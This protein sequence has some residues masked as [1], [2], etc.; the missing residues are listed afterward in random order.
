MKLFNLDAAQGLELL[1]DFS[2]DMVITSPPYDSLRS[3]EGYIFNFGKIAKEIYRIMKN[4]GVLVWIVADETIKGSESGTSF[5]QALHFKSLGFNLHDTM[6]W[7]KP[8]F[9]ATGALKTRYGQ[10]FEYMFVFSKGRPKTFN[11]IKDRKNKSYGK[12]KNG[13]VRQKNG[14]TKPISSKGNLIPEFGQRFNVWKLPGEYSKDK[15]FHPA[16]FPEKLVC[17]HI[18]SWSNEGDKVLDPMMGCGT[19]GIVC[20]KLNR[21]FVGIEISEKYFSIAKKRLEAQDD[22]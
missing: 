12:S 3:Y 16:P 7:E 8:T 22:Q 21:E 19:T 20:K 18:L 14:E 2:I 9:T 11:P 4:G 17:D 6:I 13:T 10:V 1:E 15:R 5:K